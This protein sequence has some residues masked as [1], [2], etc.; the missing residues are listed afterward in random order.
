[1][2]F[3]KIFFKQR[4]TLRTILLYIPRHQGEAVRLKFHVIFPY[5]CCVSSAVKYEGFLNTTDHPQQTTYQSTNQPPTT[6]HRPTDHRP[7]SPTTDQ[8]TTDQIHRPPTNRPPTSKTF[9][10]QKK[11]EFIF[12]IT[13]DFEYIVFKIMHCIMHTQLLREYCCMLMC[14]F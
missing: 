12:D 4:F 8:P 11:F 6:D 9:E 7:N 5:Y 13:Y 1:M 2:F 3:P 10:D 14:V